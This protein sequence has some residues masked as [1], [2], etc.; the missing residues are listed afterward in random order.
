M[1]IAFLGLGKMGLP[2]ASRL[3]A[4]GHS[5][6]VWNRTPGRGE[7]LA[8][9]G[10]RLATTPAEAVR[11]AEAVVSMLFDDAACEQVLLGTEGAI[12][13]LPCAHCST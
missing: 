1:K 7:S 11:E 8:G 2:M 4:E 10:A 13:A 6:T 12:A 5:L 9:L 3:A